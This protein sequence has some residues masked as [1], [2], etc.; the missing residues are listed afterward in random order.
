MCQVRQWGIEISHEDYLGIVCF[1]DNY[2]LFATSPAMLQT[3]SNTWLT[4]LEEAGFHTPAEDLTWCTTAPDDFDASV[5]V[6]GHMVQRTSRKIGFKVL[7]TLQTFDNSCDVEIKSRVDK[8]WKA[9]HVH[10][11]ILCCKNASMGKRLRCLQTFV[12]SSLLWGAS[13]WNVTLKQRSLLRGTQQRMMSKMLGLRRSS[14]EPLGDYCSRVHR[15]ISRLLETHHLQRW[16]EQQM[17]TYYN[18]MGLLARMGQ[19]DPQRSTYKVLRFKDLGHIA[20]LQAE[21]G[22]QT[23]CRRFHAWRLE[24]PLFK[25][26]RNWMCRAQSIFAWNEGWRSWWDF[27][28]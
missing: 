7:G 17:H 4:M 3:M 22:H 11:D 27:R 14:L 15:C 6:Q 20:A 25:H 26:D 16:D 13:S 2:W 24:W 19:R 8:A 28:C 21:F 12:A 5:T 9:F 1:A 23:H 10:R 18:F